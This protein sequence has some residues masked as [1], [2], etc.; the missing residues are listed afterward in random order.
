MRILV[1]EDD[2]TSRT[3]LVSV[4]KKNGYDVIPTKDG[5]EAWEAMSRP[6][7]PRL[8]ILDWVMPGMD[9]IDLCARIRETDTDQP[10]Y[11][12]MLTS[13]GDENHLIQG[14]TKGAN[15]YLSKPFKPGELL[16][17]IRVAERVLSLQQRLATEAATDPLTGLANR[18]AL[19]KALRNELA[20]SSRD[21]S[22]VGVAMLDI[23]FFKKVNDTWGHAVGD[24]VLVAFARRCESTLRVY[25][26]VGRYGGEEFLVIA[27]ECGMEEGFWDRLR[28]A[29]CDTPFRTMAGDLSVSASIGVTCGDDKDVPQELVRRADEALY[30][31]KSGGRNRVAIWQPKDPS[32][33]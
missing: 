28:K 4:L 14:L 5:N 24:E 3:I 2:L 29:I 30:K 15:D 26:T 9:G 1:A 13:L 21:G 32:Q 12:I 10:P 16:A 31:A 18:A 27:P 33:V 23:D 6:D 25:D 20:R 19:A 17:R 22:R 11:I 7:A 8:A